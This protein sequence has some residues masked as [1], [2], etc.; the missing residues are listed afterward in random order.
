MRWFYT[1][2]TLLTISVRVSGSTPSHINS[3]DVS[4]LSSPSSISLFIQ[5]VQEYE[6]AS[7]VIG[8]GSQP[9]L[10][11][12]VL[13][14]AL[15]TATQGHVTAS[16]L[17]LVTGSLVQ[18]LARDAVDAEASHRRFVDVEIRAPRYVINFELLRFRLMFWFTS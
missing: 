15:M 13:L 17:L 18:C 7:A 2:D 11:L 1:D 12:P 10:A 6:D 9:K 4:F 3:T 5:R 14:F 8:A 16:L